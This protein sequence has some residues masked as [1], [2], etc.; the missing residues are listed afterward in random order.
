MAA[1]GKIGPREGYLDYRTNKFKST[2]GTF[3]PTALTLMASDQ[4]YSE[5]VVKELETN[6]ELASNFFC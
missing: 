2:D 6:V 1:S 4:A 5:I 3:F